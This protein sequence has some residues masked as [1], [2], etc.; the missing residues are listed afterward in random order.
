[1]LDYSSAGHAEDGLLSLTQQPETSG[2]LAIKYHNKHKCLRQ[3][4]L[5]F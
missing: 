3:M 2:Y 5:L 4:L 1:M